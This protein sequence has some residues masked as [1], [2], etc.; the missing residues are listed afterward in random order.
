M[1]KD[2]VALVVVAAVAAWG[3]LEGWV[4]DGKWVVSAP[5]VALSVFVV[6]SLVASDAVARVLSSDAFSPV[7]RLALTGIV[8]AAV[9][10]TGASPWMMLVVGLL[11]GRGMPVA[12]HAGGSGFPGQDNDSRQE[13]NGS[14]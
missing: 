6:G 8:V 7:A 2:R 10:V 13:S 5:W 12:A 3:A 4:P 11:L 14:R 1:L 9:Y